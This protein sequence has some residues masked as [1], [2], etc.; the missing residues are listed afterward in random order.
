MAAQRNAGH[1]AEHAARFARASGDMER[2]AAACDWFRASA[3]L[4]RRRRPPRGV[5]GTW[6]A[7]AATR[8]I[9][10]ATTYLAT[11]AEAIDRGDHDAK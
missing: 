7:A 9:H 11:Q 10:D 1:R 8:L 6:N 2:L 5:P 4:L 3:A